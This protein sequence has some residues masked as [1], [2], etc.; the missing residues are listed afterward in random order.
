MEEEIADLIYDT[1][2]GNTQHAQFD[3]NWVTSAEIERNVITFRYLGQEFKV[4]IKKS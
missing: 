4:T 1:L 3:L 2:M